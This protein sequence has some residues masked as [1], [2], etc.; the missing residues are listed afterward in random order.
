MTTVRMH[1]LSN[2]DNIPIYKDKTFKVVLG[3]LSKGEWMGLV[4]EDDRFFCV[5]CTNCIG[6]VRREDCEEG[7]PVNL[8]SSYQNGE[9]KYL[10][11]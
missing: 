6:W 11:Y 7:N 9:V 5:V 8:H 1:L 3:Y 2:K 4:D 10:F